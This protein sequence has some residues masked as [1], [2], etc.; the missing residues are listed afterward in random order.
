MWYTA[1]Q[2]IKGN[3]NSEKTRIHEW[4]M[5]NDKDYREMVDL[6]QREWDALD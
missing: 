4:R 1:K 3:S 5:A 6:E 2:L